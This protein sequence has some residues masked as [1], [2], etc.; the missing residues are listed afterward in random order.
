MAT[1]V[2]AKEFLD[3]FVRLEPP[4]RQKVRELPGKFEDAIHSGVHLEKLTG[5]RDD[6]V[7]TVRVD[8][9]W[10]GVVVRL[11]GGRYALLRVLPHDAAVDWATRQRFGVNSVTGLVEILDIPTVQDRVEAVMATAPAEAASLFAGR[12]DRDF[13]T[14]GVDEE[15]IPLLRRIVDEAELYAI[16]NYL[17]AAQGDAVLLLADGKATDDVWAE[18]AEDYDLASKDVDTDDYEAALDR[19]GTKSAFIVT[20]SDAELVELLSGD[21][22]AWRTFLHPAQQ[23]MAYRPVY[24]GPARV[25][26]GAGTGKTVVAMHRAKFLAQRLLDAG[27]STSRILVATYT[28]SL[29]DNLDLTL[30]NFC[31]PEQYRRLQ[32]STVD[33]LARQT[34]S[35]AKLRLRP[36]G[37][38]QLQE[39]VDKAAT[40]AGLDEH[41]LDG[42]FLLAEW[43]QVILARKLN[44]F[45]EYGMS[46]RPGRGSRLTRSARKFVWSAVEH[47]TSELARDNQ[48]TYLQIADLA[49]DLLASRPGRPYVQVIVDEA[50]DLHPAQWRLLRAAVPLGENDLFIVGDAHQRIYD[51]RVSLTSL[52]IETRGRS[53]RLKINYRTSQ[54]IL[55]WA[56]G[57]LT[58]E[59]IDDL[60]GNLDSD[61]GY[62]S[63]FNGPAPT[64]QRF[65]TPAE[66]AEFIAAQI[67]EWLRDGVAPSAIGITARTK[68]D[69]RPVQ[70]A[71]EDAEIRWSEIGSNHKRPGVQM[72]TMHSFKGLEFARLTVVAA[73]AD[74]LPHPL[75][76]T[77]ATDDEGQH[78]LDVLRERCLLYVA[79]TRARD[80]LVVTSSGTPSHLLPGQ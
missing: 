45:A 17:P 56:L 24:N 46:P 37:S 64:I 79:C 71:L 40:M 47:L 18:L 70:T 35:A 9:F 42:R 4:V 25:T 66:E 51:Y 30:R 39:L 31:T 55:G 8:Q 77:P 29:A 67:Q 62:R 15:L 12:R 38:N 44:S 11:G 74:N 52:G 57:I 22:E 14:L 16:A 32:V 36:A 6:R 49:A 21:F 28:N 48:A 58:G 20:T 75:A 80:Q 19:P 73:N 43:E 1:L 68:R 26:G 3:D 54:Q 27:D 5:S 13:T 69:L 53:R 50:Q 72:G 10:R 78:A 33:S 41:G 7:R 76:T 34:L 60:D 2:F 59:D 61:V 63:A 23:T 65:A